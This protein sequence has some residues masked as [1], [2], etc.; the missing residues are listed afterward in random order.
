M[1]KIFILLIVSIAVFAC[2]KEDFFGY[3][4]FGEIKSIEVSNQASQAVINSNTKN[5]SI[6][7]PGGVDLSNI[8]IQKLTLSSFAT[9]DMT[10]GDT[11]NLTDSAIMKVT[12]EDGA[13]HR[14]SIGPD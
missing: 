5:V 14:P 10:I 8:K 1:K 4:S 13:S 3:S 6:E 9:S 7:I 11:I 2:V 12:A